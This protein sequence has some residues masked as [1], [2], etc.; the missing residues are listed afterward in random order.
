MRLERFGLAHDTRRSTGVTIR[1]KMGRSLRTVALRFR[2]FRKFSPL[3][4]LGLAEE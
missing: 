3:R 2:E 4:S 1:K